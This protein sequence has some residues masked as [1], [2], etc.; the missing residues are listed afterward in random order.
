MCLTGAGVFPDLLSVGIVLEQHFFFSALSPHP[1]LFRY[2]MCLRESLLLNCCFLL[3]RGGVRPMDVVSVTTSP[4]PSS[5]NHTA[6]PRRLFSFLSV[7][8]GFVSDVDIE[9]ERY[10]RSVFSGLSQIRW[11]FDRDGFCV[12]DTAAWARPVSRWAPWCAS[13]PSDPT[14]V[15][16]RSCLP[17]AVPRPRTPRRLPHG[18]P[19][20]EVSPKAWRAFATRPSTAPAPTWASANN[21]ACAEAKGSGRGRSGRGRGRGGGRGL[22]EEALAW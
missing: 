9:S 7:A 17:Q 15:A 16:C 1:S 4:P 14:R 19:S 18:G 21:E 12:S 3:C 22:G 13:L 2:D 6:V 5:T 11:R 20:P 10:V 8:W